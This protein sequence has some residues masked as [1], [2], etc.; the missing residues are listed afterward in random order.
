MRVGLTGWN[1][2]LATK[3]RED[4]RIQWVNGTDDVDYVFLLGSPTFTAETITRPEA[5]V[6]HRYVKEC[7]D[8]ID[9]ATAPIIFGSSTGVNGIE[10][11]HAGSTAY[12]LSKLFLENYIINNCDEYLICRIG[13]IVSSDYDDVVAMKPDR[14]QPRLHRGDA[15]G[16]DTQDHYLDVDVFVTETVD[17]IL[18]FKNQILEYPL[19]KLSIFQLMKMGKNRD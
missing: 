11:T 3:L 1:G 2:F 9:S 15:K 8:I 17:A 18:N 4:T 10:L 5:Q 14:V 13:T 19:E 16:I 6:M 12:N 7:I